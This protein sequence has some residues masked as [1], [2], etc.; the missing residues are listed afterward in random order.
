MDEALQPHNYTSFIAASYVKF[1]ESGGARVV[2]VLCVSCGYGGGC[3]CG[4]DNSGGLGL[5][6]ERRKKKNRGRWES[7][8][9]RIQG[10]KLEAW[11]W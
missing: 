1:Y 7:E 3:G 2:P 9:D 8:T 5:V 10:R 11:S 6:C 4:G